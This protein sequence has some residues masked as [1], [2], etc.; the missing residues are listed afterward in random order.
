M[1]AKN[2]AIDQGNSLVKIASFEGNQLMSVDSFQAFEQAK[3]KYDELRGHPTIVCSVSGNAHLISDIIDA[4]K[5]TVYTLDVSLDLPIK[6]HYETKGT[7]GMDRIA[8]V[9]GAKVYYPD[10][11]CLV[12]DFGTCITY[13]FVN[14]NNQYQGGAISPGL[15]MRFNAMNQFTRSLPLI[16]P[17]DQPVELI[18]TSTKNSMLSGVVNG[19]KAE[20]EGFI[21]MY[22][23]RFEGLKILFCGGDSGRFESIVKAPIFAAPTLVVVGLNSILRHNEDSF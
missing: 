10:D 16:E 23:S 12:V 9:C 21:D 11:H 22:S 1:S 13:D 15:N 7:L 18:G 19:I 3:E 20:V 2:F 8:A 5:N 14:K 6:N 4:G 17:D